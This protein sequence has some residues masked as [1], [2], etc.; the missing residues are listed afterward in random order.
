M[1]GWV[2]GWMGGWMAESESYITTDSQ[3]A[4]LS[5]NKAPIWGL[6]PGTYLS[7]FTN[8]IDRQIATFISYVL[9]I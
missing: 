3:L 8:Q 9:R 1:G 4:S 7:F 5:W 6:R 2:D